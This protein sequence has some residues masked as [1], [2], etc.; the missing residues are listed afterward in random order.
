MTPPADS[1]QL[2][3]VLAWARD[4]Q[5]GIEP[6]EA[7]DASGA[8]LPGLALIRGQLRLSLLEIKGVLHLICDLNVP[9][10]VR[11]ATRKL[12][13]KLQEEMLIALRQALSESPR[14]GWVLMPPTTARIGDL[15]Q[16]R[17][18]EAFRITAADPGTF[19]RFADAVQELATA[20][21]K[22]GG[23]YGQLMAG[24]VPLSGTTGR[25]DETRPG[26]A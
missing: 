17:L 1:P 2:Q 21:L 19:N 9:P 25:P 4:L 26:Y 24:P 10:Q 8:T 11:D 6:L 18:T 13:A 20:A 15:E 22:A 23:V 7:R 12:K 16:I 14:V 3:T 5:L